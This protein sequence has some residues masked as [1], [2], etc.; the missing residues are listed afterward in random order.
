MAVAQG[1]INRENYGMYLELVDKGYI[2]INAKDFTADNI[3]QHFNSIAN[4]LDDGIEDEAVH[5]MFIHLIFTD[6]EDVEFNIFHYLF[7]LMFYPI[8]LRA[9]AEI[10]S[11]KIWFYEDIT[12]KSIKSWIDHLYIKKYRTTIPQLE[13]N[14]TIDS[15]FVKFNKRLSNYQEYLANTINMKDHIDLMNQYPDFYNAVHCDVSGIPIEDVKEYGLKQAHVQIDYIKNS[16]HCL[17]DSFRTGEAISDKQFKEVYC[18]IGTKP[19]GRGGI[20]PTVINRSYITGGLIDPEDNV[21][22]S[23]IGRQAQTLSKTNVGI[24]GNYARILGLN[25]QNTRINPDPKYS[26]DTQNFIEME[27]TDEIILKE[28]DMRYYRENPKGIDKLLDAE[29]DKH[30]IGKK[31]Y[32]RSPMTC[33]SFARGQGICYKCYGDL[34]YI[35]NNINPGKYAAENQSSK[36]TQKLLSAKHLLESNIKATNWRGPYQDYIMVDYDNIMLKY[37]FDYTGYKMRLTDI[38]FDDEYDDNE[39]NYYVTSFT[40]IDPAGKEY[41]I[42]TSDSDNFYLQPDVATITNSIMAIE[43]SD[44]AELDLGE[45]QKNAHNILFKINIKNDEIQATMN[46]IKNIINVKSETLKYNKDTFLREFMETNIKGGIIINSVHYEVILA[47]QLA[48]KDNPLEFPDWTVP[49]QENYQ[50]LTLNTSLM[51][52]RYLM[53]R[54]L[55][56]KTGKVLINPSTYKVSSPSDSD[57]YAIVN[58]PDYLNNSSIHTGMDNNLTDDDDENANKSKNPFIEWR[59]KEEYIKYVQDKYDTVHKY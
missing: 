48:D 15:I 29:R 22:E 39:Y 24:S 26:C 3:E 40:I 38:D 28:F 33:A 53:T 6:G 56:N 52:S 30:L 7:N 25:C 17:R 36:L 35:N 19:N 1:L 41:D 57:V 44:S 16:D 47:N 59:S 32:F 49:N 18:N 55:Y 23:S 9:G 5:R 2:T 21:I 12:Q 4:I 43:E 51:E 42:Y 11:T 54:L 10:D 8:I 27:I 50:I 46:R 34:A 13:L 31:L 20:Y 45:M 58:A 14:Q 37:D